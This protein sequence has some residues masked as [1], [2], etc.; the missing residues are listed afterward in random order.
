MAFKSVSLFSSKEMLFFILLNNFALDFCLFPN[1]Y[2]AYHH[3]YFVVLCLSYIL[4]MFSCH[5]I[6][7]LSSLGRSRQVDLLG[8]QAGVGRPQGLQ[9]DQCWVGLRGCNLNALLVCLPQMGIDIMM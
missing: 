3:L 2:Y 1:D 6:F 8:P 9:H 7:G 4:F 5:F